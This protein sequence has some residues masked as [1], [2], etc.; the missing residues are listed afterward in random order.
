MKKMI[1]TIAI[2][3]LLVLSSFKMTDFDN[4]LQKIP[5]QDVDLCKFLDLENQSYNVTIN[6]F[7]VST[8]ITFKEYKLFMAEM[9][10]ILPE[11]QYLS[12]LPD[13]NM[14]NSSIYQKYINSSEYDNMPVVG[15]SWDNAM[16]YCKWLT[17]KNND[18]EN[19]KYI[20]RLP[21]LP[22]YLTAYNHLMRSNTNIDFNKTFAD[23]LLNANDNFTNYNY[24]EYGDKYFN[25]YYFHQANDLQ[26]LKTKMV[27]G[28]N[29]IYK[30]NQIKQN[31]ELIYYANEGYKH[32]AFRIVK[33]DLLKSRNSENQIVLKY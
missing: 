11:I 2:L 20:F 13:S 28:N 9:K 1:F 29:F 19:I 27:F 17:F 5:S 32:I 25:Y 3:M 30:R 6:E 8:F 33:V 31:N 15:I 18:K 10:N 7:E 4:K 14:I 26:I 21:T 23:W 22:E 24:M 16:K 12:L